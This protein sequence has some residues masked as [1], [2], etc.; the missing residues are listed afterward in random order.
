MLALG[1]LKLGIE[2]V[3]S[4]D[5]RFAGELERWLTRLTLIMGRRILPVDQAIA[6]ECGRIGVARTLSPIDGLL[7]AAALVH[8]LT[9]VT[10][11]V[12]DFAELGASYLNSFE[13]L[14]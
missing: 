4:R 11:N 9:V 3:R 14:Q 6:L 12:K 1:E 2:R 7:A 5:A 10:R 13:P 8:G